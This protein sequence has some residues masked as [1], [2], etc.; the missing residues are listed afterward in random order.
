M[1]LASL[2]ARPRTTGEILDDAWRSAFA[3]FP[4]LLGLS[5]LFLLPA[6]AA[7]LLLL[8]QTATAGGVTAVG[9]GLTVLLLALTGLGA[10]ACQEAFHC[11]AEGHQPRWRECLAAARRRALNHVTAHV[12]ILLLPCA[13]LLLVVSPAVPLLARWLVGAF[14]LFLCL[15]VWMLSASWHTGISAGLPNLWRVWRLSSR[16]SGRQPLKALLL[17]SSRPVLLVFAV[18][19]LH[20]LGQ[21]ALW[22]AES[23]GGFEVA[24]VPL[25]CA[26][27][28]PPYLF[29]LAALAW[30]L[31]TP[32][33]H[34][35]NY[36]FYIDAR[37]RHE[38]LD[39]WFRVEELFP[40]RPAEPPPSVLPAKAVTLACWLALAGGLLLCGP[41][42]TEAGDRLSSIRAARDEIRL[43]HS[44]VER[45]KPYPG[46]HDWVERLGRVGDNLER[47]S[48][49][50][51]GRFQWYTKA[52]AGFAERTQAQALDVLEQIDGRFGLLEESLRRPAGQEG[53]SKSDIRALLPP[54]ARSQKKPRRPEE[55]TKKKEEEK[56]LR[57]DELRE[58]RPVQGG[59]GGVVGPVGLG[60]AAPVLMYLCLGVL[61]VAVVLA[62]VLVLRQWLQN[63]TKAAPRQAGLS[64]PE[65]EDLLA[66]PDQQN[67]QS[68]WRQADELARAGNFLAAVRTLYLSVLA[69]LHQSSLIRYER[70]RTN[71]E[72]ADQLRP[73][74]ATVHSPFVRLTGLFELKWYGE[75]ACQPDDYQACR[76]LAEELRG[77][78]SLEISH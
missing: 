49:A 20:L 64:E 61:V 31:L 8:T 66:E 32:F 34:A 6:A 37:T 3:D 28:N 51:K 70:T 58:F 45:T 12:L 53:L 2:E 14:C 46:G 74:G 11:W 30:W 18:L 57:D 17:V 50:A 56:V 71:G 9:P 7:L 38:G 33:H 21:F 54:D 26:L 1:T 72:Y 24:L 68:L 5:G 13:T 29:A 59:G 39:L 78:S 15:P 48:G 22:A 69:L 42:R 52:V 41:A 77:Q 73:R 47:T 44:E 40:I 36:L 23:L 19:N 25:V 35:V 10:G 63:R 67:V 60:G 4:F 75:R 65:P 16:A 27:D 55:T 76:G 62:I 43:I